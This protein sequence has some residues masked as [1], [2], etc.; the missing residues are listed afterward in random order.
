MAS[1]VRRGERWVA[2]VSRKG[3]RASRTFDTKSAAAIWA[4]RTEQELDLQAARGGV[5]SAKGKVFGDLI[6][7]YVAELGPVKRW[8]RTKSATL[9]VIRNR[10]GDVPI[11]GFTSDVVVRYC[12]ARAA[13]GAG[14]VTVS[15]DL[16][17]ISAVVRVARGAWREDLR[18]GVVEDAR[19]ALNLLG[20][21]GKSTER[22]RRPTQQE[23]DRIVA[24]FE[25]TERRRA[26]R[27]ADL[28]QFL[29]ASGLRLGEA[30]GLRWDDLD[31]Q[32]RAITVRDRKHPMRDQR[33]DDRVPLLGDAW[34]IALRQPR[35]ADQRIFPIV[36]D[37]ASAAFTR[38]CAALSIADLHAHDL[39]HEALSRLGE[40][41]WSAPMIGSV[42][43]HR[44]PR[45]VSRY[46][47]LGPAALH[48]AFDRK[49]GD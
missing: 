39:R 37:S 5:V 33:H 2:Y 23:L 32:Q 14:R 18:P 46:V 41:G 13:E 6:D 35:G 10:L 45:M 40:R 7:R 22:A 43:G 8:G 47:Q 31:P 9:R 3:A 48:A 26:S 27:M 44:D 42:S 34:A 17:Y 25:A 16:S 15:S 20:L 21:I 36:P 24:Y 28:V 49:I 11:E 12:K 30:C 19:T 38:A 29:V 1:I 4:K